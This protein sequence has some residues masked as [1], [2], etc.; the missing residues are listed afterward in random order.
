VAS[1]EKARSCRANSG[2]LFAVLAK[3]YLTLLP[4]MY[5]LPHTR[6]LENQW[7]FGWIPS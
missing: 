7:M 5:L 4:V 2:G 1:K 3:Q 6:L